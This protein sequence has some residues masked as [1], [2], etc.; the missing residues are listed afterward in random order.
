MKTI[1]TTVI[2]GPDR[3]IILPVPQDVA[4]GAYRIVVVIEEATQAPPTPQPLD[5]PLLP[6]VAWPE[7]LSLRR[8]DLYDDWGR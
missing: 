3:T 5:L 6:A 7:H 2:V 8:E 1:E 4:L